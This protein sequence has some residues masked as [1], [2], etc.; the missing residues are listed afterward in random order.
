MKRL[1][2]KDL[3]TG[4]ADSYYYHYYCDYRHCEMFPSEAQGVGVELGDGRLWEG[5]GEQLGLHLPRSP[6]AGAAAPPCALCET[7]CMLACVPV[8]ALVQVGTGRWHRH[9][10][11][12]CLWPEITCRL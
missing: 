11:C 3:Q 2:E 12:Q 9:G 10:K 8:C 6:S 1:E 5:H 7:A 4:N